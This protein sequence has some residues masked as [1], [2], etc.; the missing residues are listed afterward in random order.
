[1][2]NPAYGGVAGGGLGVQG[3]RSWMAEIITRWGTN[4]L[5]VV[6]LA[7]VVIIATLGPLVSSHD[8]LA[9]DLKKYLERPSWENLLGT[10][11]LG[12]DTLVR[13]FVGIRLSLEVGFGSASLALVI[14]SVLG[15][16]AGYRSSF[17]SAVIMR[18]SDVLLAFPAVLLA[19]LVATV[20][21]TGMLGVILAI[22]IVSI[23]TYVRL[24]NAMMLSQ[25]H[26]QYVEA[27]VAFGASP[28]RVIFRSVL[29]NIL[30]PLVVQTAFT[31]ANAVLLEAGLSF[32]G[33]GIQPPTPSLG[34]ILHDARGFIRTHPWFGIF[35][36]LVLVILVLCLN[37]MADA[38]GR[39]ID[40]RS[41]TRKSGQTAL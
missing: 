5:P 36:G 26:L 20:F 21:K 29:P 4:L 9:Q 23:P 11:E 8:P 22:A 16:W 32:L 39:R 35:P 25:R 6:G 19:M 18:C 30:A 24:A 28:G 3:R 27:A 37:G 10:D 2:T 13:L 15:L 38:I 17:G 33:L 1:M 31:I 41:K 34:L 40:P 14:G 7:I 12:R